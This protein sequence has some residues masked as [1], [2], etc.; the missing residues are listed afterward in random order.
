[1]KKTQ[2]VNEIIKVFGALYPSAK[3]S[4]DYEDPLQLLV[5]TQLSAQCTDQR[6]NIVAKSLYKKY[7]SIDSFADAELKKLEEEI[8][9]TGFYHN[10]AKNIKNCCIMIIEK[11]EGKIPDNLED[12]L[13]LPG[14]GRKTANLFLSDIY[15]IPG[16]VVDTHAR[17]LSQRIGLTKN[18]NPDKIEKDLMKIVPKEKWNT[19]CHQLVWHGRRVCKARRP[20]CS[21]CEIFDYCDKK[22]VSNY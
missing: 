14:V 10:K 22:G 5:S 11:F 21:N 19:F 4:L 3:T 12:M 8:K 18:N 1:M 20:D 17:R 9:P 15:G 2:K 7:D 13:K 6:V 16:I